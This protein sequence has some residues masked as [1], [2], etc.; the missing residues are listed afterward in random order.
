MTDVFSFGDSSPA[1]QFDD[2]SW[3]S[4]P[5][6]ICNN[7]RGWKKTPNG[8]NN[9]H[10]TTN[11]QNETLSNAGNFFVDGVSSNTVPAEPIVS[12]R[13]RNDRLSDFNNASLS[14]QSSSSLQNENNLSSKSNA[15]LLNLLLDSS[16]SGLCFYL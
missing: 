7:W 3:M 4:E 8:S 13:N 14:N 5:E 15:Q 2:D 10:R 11:S 1:E 6:S 12:V 9:E 16:E